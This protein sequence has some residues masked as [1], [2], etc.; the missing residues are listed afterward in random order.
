MLLPEN[1]LHT[2][3]SPIINTNILNLVAGEYKLGWYG[4]HGFNHWVRVRDNGLKLAA[5]TGAKTAI[6][7]LFAFFHDCKRQDDI[8]DPDHGP[9]A[10]ALLRKINKRHIK[11][12]SADLDLLV[13]AC[14]DHTYGFLEADITVQTCWDADRLDIGRVG[15][16]PLQAYLCTDAAKNLEMIKWAYQRSIPSFR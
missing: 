15:D 3:I 5:I 6:V 16:A 11:L 1:D 14:R 4:I 10:A 8:W 12:S 13:I 9:R 2:S 7:E